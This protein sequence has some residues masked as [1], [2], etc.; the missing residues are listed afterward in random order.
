MT[1]EQPSVEV[2]MNTTAGMRFYVSHDRMGTET[3]RTV[4]GKRTFT[5]STFDR[6]I[7]QERA[8][9]A[10]QDLFRNGEFV[11]VRK[12]NDTNEEEVASDQ[13]FTD[14]ELAGVVHEVMAENK[15]MAEVVA[16]VD[17]LPLLN[18]FQEALVLEDAPASAIEAVKDRIEE[19]KGGPEVQRAEVKASGSSR[20][21][22]PGP[23]QTK[24]DETAS[25]GRELVPERPRG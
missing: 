19:V 13:S 22:E 9:N 23:T 15:V 6:Q 18:R 2:W 24:A 4:N 5:I 7:N 3:T 16:G 25:P 1:S 20:I 8:A 21:P 17:S 14:A 10:K 12:G 11:L